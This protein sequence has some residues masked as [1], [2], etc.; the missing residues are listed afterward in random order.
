MTNRLVLIAAL[1][2]AVAGAPAHAQV[3]GADTILVNGKVV[4]LD[5]ASSIVQAVAIHDGKILAVG[6]EISIA[7]IFTTE[8]SGACRAVQLSA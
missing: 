7:W 1:T 3:P 6:A 8:N 5:D 4:T 2:A